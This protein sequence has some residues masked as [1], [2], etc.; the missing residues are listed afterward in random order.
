MKMKD[1]T[2]DHLGNDFGTNKRLLGYYNIGYGVLYGR[3]LAG[4][5]LEKAL[6]TP[7][8]GSASKK[9][10]IEVKTNTIKEGNVKDTGSV[11]KAGGAKAN[12]AAGTVQGGI[13]RPTVDHLGNVFNSHADML[14]Y[15]GI[16]YEQFGDRRR[17]GWTLEQILTKPKFSTRGNG[18]MGNQSEISTDKIRDVA[19]KYNL[20]EQELL[21]ILGEFNNNDVKISNIP[22]E[23]PKKYEFKPVAAPQTLKEVLS[24]SYENREIVTSCSILKCIRAKIGNRVKTVAYD[25]KLVLENGREIV[26]PNVSK[27]CTSY[28][29][30]KFS[31][32]NVKK[33]HSTNDH[34]ALED[35]IPSIFIADARIENFN[36]DILK[37]YDFSRVSRLLLRGAGTPD[38][39]CGAII[40][41]RD[42]VVGLIINIAGVKHN[43]KLDNARKLII[44]RGLTHSLKCDN[45]LYGIH[46]AVKAS[47]LYGAD[48]IVQSDTLGA[49]FDHTV[50]DSMFGL[51]NIR[52]NYTMVDLRDEVV[53][54]VR[55]QVISDISK[56]D[57][58]SKRRDMANINLSG[59]KV[60]Y[61]IYIDRYCDSKSKES[62]FCAAN[63]GGRWVI[64]RTDNI[65]K[66]VISN[67]RLTFR[68]IPW[69]IE[70]T[71]AG[72]IFVKKK[73][74]TA[75]FWV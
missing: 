75:K 21:K 64:V 22:A 15:Y 63:V 35:G 23:K 25:F 28:I 70:D 67:N 27:E 50:A 4:W 31:V 37:F 44:D 17:Q 48:F 12:Y 24:G 51:S 46:S 1:L 39:P 54:Y 55:K 43:Y 2:R 57:I 53:E 42:N 40:D 14:N 74:G 60:A 18:V 26:Y 7:T 9:E 8:G 11:A 72:S 30:S 68:Y 41:S 65:S 5:S 19:G 56:L 38:R 13:S 52:L 6:T 62:K 33:Y 73:D 34:I 29:V 66:S 36:A 20:T 61:P 32:N 59:V 16:T 69:Y 49:A 45:K 3:L 10:K 47:K 58:G 71:S